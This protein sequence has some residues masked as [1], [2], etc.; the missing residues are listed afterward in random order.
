MGTFKLFLRSEV[1][2]KNRITVLAAILITLLF[3]V[4]Q[5]DAAVTLKAE[6][7]NFTGAEKDIVGPSGTNKDG[8]ND[9]G[10]ALTVS[11][12]QAIRQIALKNDTTGAVWST[13]PTAGQSL[14][15]V[16]NSKGELLN[17]SGRMAITP[18]L[19]AG[20]F[21]LTI[22][23]AAA[24]LPKD[25]K[26]TASVTLI[27]KAVTSVSTTVK[28]IP[29]TTAKP[30]VVQPTTN[31]PVANTAKKN[32]ILLFEGRGQSDQD[33][34]GQKERLGSDG[35]ND[36]RFDA[37]FSLIQGV[38]VTGLK[39]TAESDGKTITWDTVP[40]NSV[41]LLAVVDSGNS[42]L[43]KTDG[44]VSFQPVSNAIYSLYAQDRDGALADRKS[45][46]KLYA[47]LS[48]GQM[49]EKTATAGK[50]TAAKGTMTAELRGTANYDFVGQNEKL[51]A[52]MN[53][54]TFISIVL[55]ANATITG[56]RVT[57][58]KNGKMWD[59]IAGNGNYL[60]AVLSTKG[61]KFNK[62]DGSVSI[63]AKGD[64]ELHVAFDADKDQS[65]PYKVTAVLSNGQLM[66]AATGS[67][68][69]AQSGTADTQAGRS[70]AF[71]SKKP[72][73]VNLD[74]VGK[75]KKKKANGAKDMVLS[76]KMT[77]QGNITAIT[78]TDSSGKGWDTL[79]S[80]NGRWLL[81]VRLGSKLMN[82]K[83]GSVKLPVNGTKT[84]QLLM[85]NNGKLNAKNGVL[86]LTVTW[87]D[88][89]VTES[90]LK[91]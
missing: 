42:I 3:A 38:S 85:Q 63:P 17:K 40:G 39:I 88:G 90:A 73:Q 59:T 78:L 57:N 84:Y 14:L 46:V 87:G 18:V 67:I 66:E 50:K 44:T 12:A 29:A 47:S 71:I 10:F 43:N 74:Q 26:F 53:P 35:K 62:A 32:E 36:F 91:W 76:I 37:K 16:R 4:P 7:L 28:G 9:A 13:S 81:G 86:H 54:D 5:C 1:V 79:P 69:A 83:N 27:D 8:K 22:N 20:E 49:V 56:L 41:P 65:G 23:D 19:L 33:L 6:S 82:A 45:V 61:D 68:Q 48:N 60:T 72:T 80:N 55:N 31:Q 77:G 11:G 70:P 58:L 15:I 52:N 24:A 21:T 2:M 75:N 34:A 25:S 51:S 64:I 89:E 30:A